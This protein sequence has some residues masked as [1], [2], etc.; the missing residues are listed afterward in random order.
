MGG[1]R[2]T[3]KIYTVIAPTLQ[4]DLSVRSPNADGRDIAQQ[5]ALIYEI[6]PDRS[7]GNQKT[8]KPVPNGTPVHWELIGFRNSRERPFYSTAASNDPRYSF[9]VWDFTS[10][11]K[12]DRIYFGPASDVRTSLV[13]VAGEAGAADGD[14]NSLAG[15]GGSDV[16]VIPEEYIIRASVSVGGQRSSAQ[17]A[18]C[19]LPFNNSS[20]QQGDS[21]YEDGALRTSGIYADGPSPQVDI[22][23]HRSFTPTETTVQFSVLSVMCRRWRRQI[24]HQIPMHS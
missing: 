3:A 22:R 2:R 4:I 17:A 20:Y 23:T 24:G 19:L 6:D 16:F 12:S 10:A 21:F 11:G 13:T 7:F 18:A 5:R 1:F 9:G 15:G 8:V 14:S